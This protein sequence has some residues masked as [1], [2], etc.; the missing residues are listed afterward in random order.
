V[1]VKSY[2]KWYGVDRYTAYVELG[3]LGVQLR[4]ED[5]RWAVRPP[6]APRRSDPVRGSEPSRESGWVEVG[7]VLM[8]PVGYTE[9]GMP[10]GLT[11]DDLDP[12]EREVVLAELDL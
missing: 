11:L 9:G 2:A 8:F 6:P 1:T 10:F 5:S 12:E 3:M 7:G 4:P